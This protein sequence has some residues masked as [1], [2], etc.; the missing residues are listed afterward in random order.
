VI[1][2]IGID[3]VALPRIGRA[4]ER[5][6]DRFMQRVLSPAERQAVRGNPVAYVAGRFA[7]KEAGLKAL[8]TGVVA[9]IG[10]QDVEIL[11]LDSGAPTIHYRAGALARLRAMGV[12]AA[13][14]T[15]THTREHA[16]AF[17][18]LE[19]ADRKPSPPGDAKED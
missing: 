13:H 2:G 9:G 19:A 15:L 4:L 8:G 11:R 18:V 12:T 17:V 14:V 3:M 6:G 16:A 7:A 1:A 5:F 10:W